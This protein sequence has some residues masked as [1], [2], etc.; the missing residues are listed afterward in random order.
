MIDRGNCIFKCR[1]FLERLFT[2]D[3]ESFS[4]HMAYLPYTIVKFHAPLAL[5]SPVGKFCF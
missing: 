2:N 5:V 4:K 3:K 1:L